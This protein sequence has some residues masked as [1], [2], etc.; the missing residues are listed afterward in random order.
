MNVE[1]VGIKPQ[2]TIMEYMLVKVVRYS[3]NFL[4]KNQNHVALFMFIYED[5]HFICECLITIALAITIV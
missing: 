3:H 4:L 1:F 2:A 5:K